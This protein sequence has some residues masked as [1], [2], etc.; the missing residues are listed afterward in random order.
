MVF[1]YKVIMWYGLSELSKKRDQEAPL[2]EHKSKQGEKKMKKIIAASAAL[3]LV[4]SAVVASAEVTFTGD[5][6]ERLIMQR[7]YNFGNGVNG[8]ESMNDRN[9][10]RVRVVV[11]AVT[12]GGAYANMRLRF[13][14]GT[15][16]GTL[17]TLGTGGNTPTSNYYTDWA[18][19][20]I[21]IGP[22]TINAGLMP[23]T[24]S[25]WFRYDKRFDRLAATWANK[26]TSVTAQ[27]DKM[28][29]QQLHAANGDPTFGD[30]D[31]NEW[32]LVLKQ[33]FAAD[34]GLV[35]YGV[36]S[37]NQTVGRLADGNGHVNDGSGFAG[38]A[39]VEGPAGPVKLMAELSYVQQDLMGFQV[40]G[41]DVPGGTNAKNALGQGVLQKDGS[42]KYE[43][44][45]GGILHAKMNFGPADGTFIIGFTKGGFEADYNYGFL[46]MG[47]GMA[48]ADPAI[49]NVGSPIT[50]ISRIGQS[51]GRSGASSDTFFLGAI[52]DY[53]IN[54][55]IKLVGIVAY[56]D[57]SDYNALEISGLVR[58]DVTDGAYINLG[59]GMLAPSISKTYY[60][61]GI[62]DDTAYGAFT[63]LGIKF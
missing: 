42:I 57:A 16:D 46:M 4:G 41:Q 35:A 51:I 33:K 29:E 13:S 3:L 54:K 34:W 32:G 31:W 44:G 39:R 52:G 27:F 5:A 21:P 8:R 1:L 26:M 43:N 58:F 40:N 30:M 10:G 28:S 49:P 14:D 50:A 2:S 48:G 56:A 17:A 38:T 6:R 63:E 62:Q 7:D 61:A 25:L 24:A 36:Y 20:G 23:D 9:T 53:Q 59:A 11:N 55:M 45:Y 37:D 47:G 22:V 18:Y 12:K 19:I 60:G 15:Y